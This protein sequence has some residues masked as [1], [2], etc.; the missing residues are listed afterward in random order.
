MNTTPLPFPD[1]TVQPTAAQLFG[2]NYEP[3]FLKHLP[4][5]IQFKEGIVPRIDFRISRKLLRAFS[6]NRNLQLQIKYPPTH[7]SS[8]RYKKKG[9]LKNSQQF[10]ND[11]DDCRQCLSNC[12][13]WNWRRNSKICS[14]TSSSPRYKHINREAG[15]TER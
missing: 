9:R 11:R 3:E 15:S 14:R 2:S 12:H 7:S 8:A 13:D 4:E 6:D 1:Q 5:I 10:N